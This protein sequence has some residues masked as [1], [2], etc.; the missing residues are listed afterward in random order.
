MSTLEEEVM[1]QVPDKGFRVRFSNSGKTRNLDVAVIYIG[2][3]AGACGDPADMKG[4]KLAR[5]DFYPRK[6]EV[7]VSMIAPAN[8]L[9]PIMEII[10][11]ELK[12]VQHAHNA[13][14]QPAAV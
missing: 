10:L 4:K 13:S 14:D 1:L 8:Q 3:H 7:P 6:G 5:V 12:K 9:V 2:E 11:H